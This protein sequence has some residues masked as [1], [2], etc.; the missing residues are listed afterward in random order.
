MEQAIEIAENN[1]AITHDDY[2]REVF[3]AAV[4]IRAVDSEKGH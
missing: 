4:A 3:T 2:W 1:V